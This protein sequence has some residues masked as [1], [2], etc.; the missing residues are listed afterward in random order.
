MTDD[1]EGGDGA[2]LAALPAPDDKAPAA[3]AR[4]TPVS[5]RRA[6]ATMRP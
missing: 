5:A 1:G 4:P 6:R 3:G 2:L